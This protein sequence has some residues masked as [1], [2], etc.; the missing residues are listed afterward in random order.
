[1]AGNDRELRTLGDLRRAID[2]L[3][4]N[5]P[6]RHYLAL[7]PADPTLDVDA[8][9]EQIAVTPVRLDLGTIDTAATI[10]LTADVS[11]GQDLRGLLAAMGVGVDLTEGDRR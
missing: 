11:V 10:L 5:T 1:M 8:L 7:R 4:D 3:P 2:G 9:A 6:L